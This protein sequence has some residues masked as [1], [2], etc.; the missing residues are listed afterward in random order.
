MRKP[1]N[2]ERNIA[3]SG[4]ER[5]PGRLR[6]ALRAHRWDRMLEIP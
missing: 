6:D 3:V 2:V 5:L 1:R 4:G